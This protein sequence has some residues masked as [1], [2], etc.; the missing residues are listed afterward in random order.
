MKNI[1]THKSHQDTIPNCN[2]SYS[3]FCPFYWACMINSLKY[4]A[5]FT[6]AHSNKLIEKN[7]IGLC[8]ESTWHVMQT[9]YFL[10]GTSIILMQLSLLNTYN[11]KSSCRLHMI[12][13]KIVE[14]SEQCVNGSKKWKSSVV[15]KPH[16]LLRF[17][18][19]HTT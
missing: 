7:Y 5:E 18:N 17:S 12:K 11:L 4:A 3:E 13:W 9:T 1:I 10:S 14:K 16:I 8:G 15:E 19:S 6:N 2:C